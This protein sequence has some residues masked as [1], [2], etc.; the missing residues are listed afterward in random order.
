MLVALLAAAPAAAEP[1]EDEP[2]PPVP[3][4]VAAKLDGTVARMTAQVGFDVNGPDPREGAQVALPP[5]AVVTSAV[6]TIGGAS[7]TLELVSADSA[8]QAMEALATKAG[9]AH[10]AW[11]L[12]LSSD[13][14]AAELGIDVAAP[15]KAHV[16][17]TLQLELSTCFYRDMR[18]AAVPEAWL[19]AI[20]PALVPQHVP[21]GLGG[22]CGGDADSRWIAFPDGELA[23]RPAG[24]ERIGASAGRLPLVSDHLV[25]LELAIARTMS[26]VPADLHTA[27]VI[28]A[29]RS[30]TLAEA[31]AQRAI[32]AAYLRAAPLGD[33]Q[34]IE[35]A[36][37]ARPLLPAWMPARLAAAR[38]D[39]A[40]GELPPRNGSNLDAGIAEAAAWLARVGGTHRMIVFTDERLANRFDAIGPADLQRLVGEGTLVHVVALSGDPGKLERSDDDRFATFAAMTQ[41]IAVRGGVD[42]KGS[43]DATLLAR[44][45]ALDH[46]E[47]TAPGWKQISGDCG[48]Q[49]TTMP[50]G[51]SCD[52]WARGTA[53]AGP[54]KVI[55]LLWNKR[56]ERLV[57]PDPSR[58]RQVARELSTMSLLEDELQAQ[59]EHAAFAVNRAW[60]LFATWGGRDGYS[61][62]QPD[63][64]GFGS[65]GTCGCGDGGISDRFGFARGGVKLDLR[66]QFAKAVA[67]CRRGDER[68]EIAI[69]TTREEIVGVDVTTDSAIRDC[70]ADGVWDT[71][72]AI[73]NAPEH[74]T[75]RF[76]F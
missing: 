1:P 19:P 28:D 44:P 52:W 32:V 73:P 34:L 7:H 12:R 43:V 46:V 31:Q 15:V 8:Q 14:G 75:T 50:E 35:Y 10:R 48:T 58:A 70:I 2:K 20:E 36:R 9:G 29:S 67:A 45:I 37:N 22:A 42:D 53:V 11:G 23:A 27:I 26:E 24:V 76:V 47:V 39:R 6:A 55:G 74:A 57:R 62:V 17:L 60:S 72:V 5:G 68:V 38:I 69:E 65:I 33:V 21:M 71:I 49:V 40:L 18:Y 30:V 16:A 64:F 41:G 63:G 66:E 25:K 13:R 3:S 4:H 56:F 61:D 51:E 59:V 54:V